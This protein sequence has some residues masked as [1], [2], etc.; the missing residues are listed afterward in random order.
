MATISTVVASPEPDTGPAGDQEFGS[1]P[2]A[3]SRATATTL[4]STAAEQ[5]LIA[6]VGW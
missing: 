6:G 4:P 2:A 3:S 1:A 5:S